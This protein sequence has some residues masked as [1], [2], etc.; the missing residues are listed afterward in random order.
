MAARSV[1]EFFKGDIHPGD[2]FL[3]NDPYHG[4]NH[5]PDRV[6][7]RPDVLSGLFSLAN[8]DLRFG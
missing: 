1:S 5:L 4:G 3:L 7:A 8:F 2:V 6:I